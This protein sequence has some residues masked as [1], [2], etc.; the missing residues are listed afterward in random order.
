MYYVLC[1]RRCVVI[2][3]AQKEFCV[4]TVLD[5]SKQHWL[6]LS[7]LSYKIFRDVT[8]HSPESRVS[9]FLLQV[10]IL[11]RDFIFNIPCLALLSTTSYDHT[12]KAQRSKSKIDDLSL[13]NPHPTST[14]DKLC[15]L[16]T[17]ETADARGTRPQFSEFGS[18]QFW[19]CPVQRSPDHQHRN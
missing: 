12:H 1:V 4:R 14:T 6:Y 5:V 7:F 17:T 18:A 9:M 19:W 16:V 15:D 3:M 13:P 2:F 11:L 8:S 10:E